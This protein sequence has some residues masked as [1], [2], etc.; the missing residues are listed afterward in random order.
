MRWHCVMATESGELD[1]RVELLS[2]GRCFALWRG[3]IVYDFVKMGIRRFR[4]E[5]DARE[6]RA[7]CDAA[8]RLA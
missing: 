7:L 1:N 5:S 6:C 2:D 8:D 3:R 4:K